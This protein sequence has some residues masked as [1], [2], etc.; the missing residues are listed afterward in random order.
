MKT[1][2]A[3]DLD[4]TLVTSKSEVIVINRLTG[5]KNKI[6][7]AEF[8]T[9]MPKR[10]ETLDF[11]EFD[12][13]VEPKTIQKNFKTFSEIL[14]KSASLPNSKTIILT[15]RTSKIKSDL[16]KFL[17]S[18]GLP[19]ITI[20]GVG[21]SDPQEKAKVIQSYI[22]DGYDTIKFYDD[23]LKNVIAVKSLQKTNPEVSIKATHIKH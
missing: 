19:P 14:K 15:A 5:E 4:D 12:K 22:N 21:S 7:P 3:W 6:S 2:Y 1:L 20:H 18:H 10:G 9:Y 8:A 17:S 13:L 16:K 23:S 11:S